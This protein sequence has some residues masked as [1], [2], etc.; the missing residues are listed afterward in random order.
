[1]FCDRRYL[2]S[3]RLNLD[4]LEDRLPVSEGIGTALSLAAL[5]GMSAPGVAEFGQS[6]QSDYRFYS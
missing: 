6:E 3:I 2:R 1:M 4:V 5:V